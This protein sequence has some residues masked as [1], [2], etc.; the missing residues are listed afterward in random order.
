ME[1]MKKSR[2]DALR[3]TMTPKH[4]NIKR[5]IRGGNRSTS[6]LFRNNP[7]N[8]LAVPGENSF[9]GMINTVSVTNP[10]LEFEEQKG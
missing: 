10:M 5:T 3:M 7:R 6:M 1:S 2:D 4:V 9:G 8:T